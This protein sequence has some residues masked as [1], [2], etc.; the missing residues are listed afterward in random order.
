MIEKKKFWQYRR[1]FI[2]GHT[3][4]KGSWL[5]M[6]LK[7]LGA[8]IEG[9]SLVPKKKS[10][11]KIANIE[12]DIN[13]NHYY[14]IRD[15]KVLKKKILNFKPDVIFHLAAQPLVIESYLNPF[16]T[17]DVNAIG[18]LNLMEIVRKLNY[19]GVL[20]NVTTDKVYKIIK[21]KKKFSEE[22]EIGV[23]D[24]YGSSKVC[25]EI[26]AK[27]YFKS[28][29][30]NKNYFKVFTVRSGNVIGGG[31]FSKNRIIPDFFLL[32][33][34]KKKNF[35]VRN[36]NYTRPWQFV[37]EPLIGYILLAEKMFLNKIKY[38]EKNFAWNFGPEL[39]DSVSV[40]QLCKTLAKNSN[41]KI[42]ITR[43]TRINKKFK[44]TQFLYLNSNKAKKLLGWKNQYNLKTAL[45]KI[46]EW[47]EASNK[48][49]KIICQTQIDEYLQNYKI[50]NAR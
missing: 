44:E 32:Q 2:T 23:T 33:N 48:F 14:D 18:T 3:G 28:F 8:S 4:F 30:M 1:V 47:Y 11:F 19:N 5:C 31:D 46:V 9:Y 37:L 6:I 13:R 21:N 50:K 22:D 40:Y 10:I 38:C 35:F 39:K 41:K 20:I 16:K 17:F 25:S 15:F 45:F 36:P 27:S 34:S 7:K 42:K 49:K 26:I 29:L 24:P 43:N 12:K